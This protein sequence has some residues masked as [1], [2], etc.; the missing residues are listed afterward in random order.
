MFSG[1]LSSVSD[2][3]CF[4]P[5]PLSILPAWGAHSLLNVQLPQL[6]FVSRNEALFKWNPSDYY[7]ASAPS[8]TAPLKN[9]GRISISR[10]EFG[11][12]GD[13]SKAPVYPEMEGLTAEGWRVKLM[14]ETMKVITLIKDFLRGNHRW[15]S[16]WKLKK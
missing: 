4:H 8:K 9:G 13:S 15:N 2:P 14:A 12:S 7:C 5:D 11:H 3:P 16:C 10:R 6:F 1:R